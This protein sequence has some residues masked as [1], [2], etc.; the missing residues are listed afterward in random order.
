M[1]A[2]IRI[3]RQRPK[4]RLELRQMAVADL[5]S[6][7]FL[8]QRRRLAKAAIL[9]IGSVNKGLQEQ[10]SCLGCEKWTGAARPPG[11]VH[12]EQCVRRLDSFRNAN[13]I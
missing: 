12:G 7:Q 6:V 3:S 4:Q 9:E 8:S 1:R 10:E 2:M 11:M 5:L 13:G